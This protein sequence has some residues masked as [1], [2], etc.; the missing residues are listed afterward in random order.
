MAKV[1]IGQASIDENGKIKNGQ[2]GDQTGKETNVRDWYANTKKSGWKEM[3]R[4]NDSL[5]ASKAANAMVRLINSNLVGYDQNERNTLW[6]A[7]NKYDWSVD[8]YIA[9]GE[10]TE[11]DCSAFVYAVYCTVLPSLRELM[12]KN[13][14][15]PTCQTSWNVYN[16]YGSGKFVRSIETKFLNSP[17]YLQVGDLLNVPGSHIVMVV[18]TDGIV[19]SQDSPSN[20]TKT[21]NKRDSSTNKSSNKSSNNKTTNTV[22]N[23]PSATKKKEDEEIDKDEE[24][25]HSFE[26]LIEEMINAAPD[27]GRK[28]ITTSEL[29]DSNILKTP[30]ESTK[31]VSKNNQDTGGQ[32][33]IGQKDFPG[34]SDDDDFNHGSVTQTSLLNIVSGDDTNKSTNDVLNGAIPLTAGYVYTKDGQAT[35]AEY[36]AVLSDGRTV[37]VDKDFTTII[38]L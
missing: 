6:K 2:A 7:L 20:E 22:P 29:F 34:Y 37:A 17:D 36:R 21:T 38:E 10:K 15:S 13:R 5:V 35:Y 33:T 3:I 23:L 11:T 24:R 30:Q 31:I 12:E 4:C 9:S 8:K 25:E 14:N 19:K 16:R 1:K 32:N 26:S 27:M 28:I 18:S